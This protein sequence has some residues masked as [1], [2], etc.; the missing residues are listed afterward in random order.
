[1][2]A[3][4]K[5]AA[6]APDH[7]VIRVNLATALS[8]AGRKEAAVAEYRKAV[9]LAP[10]VAAVRYNYGVALGQVGDVDGALAEFRAAAKLDP[11]NKQYQAAAVQTV[12]AKAD[13]DARIAPPP[14]PVKR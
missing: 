10:D 12:R 1:V 9:E 5:A 3:L 8:A 2:A 6:L 7:P 13:R 14:R 11:G 4:T